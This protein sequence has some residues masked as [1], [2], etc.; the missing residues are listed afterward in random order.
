MTAINTNLG[1]LGGNQPHI[2]LINAPLASLAQML[3]FL[4][5]AQDQ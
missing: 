4:I 2:S 3:L 1:H 5:S